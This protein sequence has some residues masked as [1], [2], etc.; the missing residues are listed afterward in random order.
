MNTLRRVDF[1]GGF[2]IMWSQELYTSSWKLKIQSPMGKNCQR[3][4]SV[5]WRFQETTFTHPKA[6]TSCLDPW[7]D[8]GSLWWHQVLWSNHGNQRND[9]CRR[10]CSIPGMGRMR[11]GW[12][13]PEAKK[14]KEHYGGCGFW[15]MWYL[16]MILY[17][18]HAHIYIYI[19]TNVYIP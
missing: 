10:S 1:V 17:V 2:S 7:V 6:R 8:L 12:I 15:E 13:R 11:S 18:D 19:Y 3:T 16:C 9:H 5:H 4:I 14:S